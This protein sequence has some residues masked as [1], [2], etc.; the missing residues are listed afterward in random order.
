VARGSRLSAWALLA[1]LLAG[2][3]GLAWFAPREALDWQP[4]LALR[5][6]W[7][8]MTAALVHWSARHLGANLL[9]ALVV[10]AVGWAARL[11]TSAAL[12]WLVAW[13][14][15]QFGLLLRPDLLHYGGL[16]GVLH[17]GVA[18]AALWLVFDKRWLGVA[19]LA[20]LAV[21]LLLE[22]PWGPPLRELAGWDILIAPFAHAT[23]AV[24]GALCALCV[25]MN[26]RTR[27]RGM[28]C[29]NRR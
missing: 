4:E 25:L 13:P 18:V 5:E 20:G 8:A 24:A 27:S 2:M 22:A 9:G 21:K 12:A 19:M 15:T 28:R 29:V 14:L 26:R 23:G 6:P 17:A 7:R 1:A 16:S 3:A 11:P 10:A